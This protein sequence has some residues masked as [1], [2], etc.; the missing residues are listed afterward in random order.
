MK[1]KD[2][3]QYLLQYLE[4]LDEKGFTTATWNLTAHQQIIYKVL[5]TQQLHIFPS[6]KMLC[7]HSVFKLVFESG[8]ER[9]TVL[10]GNLLEKVQNF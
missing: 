5:I 6:L 8:C 1:I 3:Q 7:L 2:T 4:L 9:N 10:S